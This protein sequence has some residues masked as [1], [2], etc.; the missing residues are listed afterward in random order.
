MSGRPADLGAAGG[1]R[2][3][4][5]P[6]RSRRGGP[7]LLGGLLILQGAPEAS[8]RRPQ[9]QPEGRAGT[10]PAARQEL[11]GLCPRASKAAAPPGGAMAGGG[12]GASSQGGPPSKC[13]FLVPGAS[14]AARPGRWLPTSR[15]WLCA[16]SGLRATSRDGPL[17]GQRSRM[18]QSY[19][20]SLPKE[21]EGPAASRDPGSTRSIR[22]HSGPIPRGSRCPLSRDRAVEKEAD[23]GLSPAASAPG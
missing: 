22:S 1:P 14:A 21:S 10:L 18:N 23:K 19:R 8:G 7:R 2:R 4:P 12:A 11:Q 17:R 3:G 20:L 9:P 16:H 5:L 13:G 6:W 15:Q